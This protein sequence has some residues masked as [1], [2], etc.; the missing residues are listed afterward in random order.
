MAD[1]FL[2]FWSG[3]DRRAAN[4]TIVFQRR[5]NPGDVWIEKAI[6][7]AEVC[8]I[9]YRHPSSDQMVI[10][11]LDLVNGNDPAGALRRGLRDIHAELV[12]LSHWKSMDELGIAGAS[13]VPASGG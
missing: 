7:G 9:S 8:E 6:V 10:Q 5:N 2:R 3:L 12:V 11:D 13:V 4:R 1:I